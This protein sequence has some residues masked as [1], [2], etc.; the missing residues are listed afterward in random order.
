MTAGSVPACHSVLGMHLV[1][2]GSEGM[3]P[4]H[5]CQGYG[6]SANHGCSEG[7][8]GVQIGGSSLANILSPLVAK[9]L[10]LIQVDPLGT[11]MWWSKQVK[12][13]STYLSALP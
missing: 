1:S 3:A 7:G 8:L 10:A 4:M 13:S 6:A 12:H 9:G 2:S 11:V 5:F